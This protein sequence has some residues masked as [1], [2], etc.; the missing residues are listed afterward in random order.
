MNKARKQLAS[1]V[2]PIVLAVP[3]CSAS[4]HQAPNLPPVT[5]NVRPQGGDG[6]IP[7]WIVQPTGDDFE[8]P[9]CR[10]SYTDAACSAGAQGPWG[11][12]C[13]GNTLNYF[14]TKN[15]QGQSCK[16]ACC[17][18]LVSNAASTCTALCAN[19]YG[20]GWTGT[21]TVFTDYCATNINSADCECGPPAP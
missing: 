21:C 18:T 5:E 3:A 13:V 9:Q 14:D 8:T 17:V 19:K 12:T 15:A 6:G 7:Y 1:L 16:G 11:N 10:T 4:D 20:M 2:V